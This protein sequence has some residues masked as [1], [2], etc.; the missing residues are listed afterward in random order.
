MDQREAA[1]LLCACLAGEKDSAARLA[2]LLPA[3]WLSLA[4]RARRFKVEGLLYRATKSAGFP[5]QRIPEEFNDRLRKAYRSQAT[6]SASLFFAAANVLRSLAEMQLPV[7]ALKGLALAKDIYGDIALRPMSDIDL[8][9][10]QEDLVRAGRALLALGYEQEVPAWESTLKT[11]HHLPP[12]TKPG[13]T[14]IELHWTIVPPDSPL[15]VDLDGLWARA[16]V[17]QVDDVEVRAFSPE[18]L[19]L[20]L[21]IHACFHLQTGSDLI[22]LCDLAG[23]MKTYAE[24][25]DWRT[26]IQ[27][28]GR[29]G[30]HKCVYLVLLLVR[31]LLKTAPPAEVMS[32]M[33]PNDYQP[34]FLAEALEQVFAEKPS[35]QLIR[36]RFGKLAGIKKV[37]GIQSQATAFFRE[38]FPSRAYMARIYP[39]SI[40][41]PRIYLC[42]VSRLA[43]L[44]VYFTK[45]LFRLGRREPSVVS[46]A[47][48]E[49]RV[50]TVSDWMFSK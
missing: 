43:R 29:W 30:G 14:T 31:E 6:R 5:T 22:P 47:D 33:M 41:S 37:K 42:Y 2:N 4:E 10:K 26:V 34:A 28:A 36:R 20:H 39:V 18:D 24:K 44:T 32:E 13:G 40:S 9:L 49:L 8:L 25:I 50:R 23:V 16:H 1:R 48:Q 15:E 27:R 46:A 35:S 12:F 21:C 38:V 3:D 17:I 7:I 45:L 11:Y 19:F